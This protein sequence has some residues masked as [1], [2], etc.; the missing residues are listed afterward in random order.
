MNR[1][2]AILLILSSLIFSRCAPLETIATHD[3]SSGYYRLDVKDANPS[4]V[5]IDLN[6][7]SLTLFSMKDGDK[8]NPDPGS[9]KHF[10][11]SEL[12]PENL[13][14]SARF[15][16]N[17]VDA[18]LATIITKYRP[19][20]DGVP[21][22]MNS[23]LNAALYVGARKDFFSI[24]QHKQVFRSTSF[25]RQTGFDAGLFAGFG[26]SFISPTV[27]A[28]RTDREYDGIIF[29]KGAAVFFTYDHISLGLACGFDN[30]FG[31]DSGIWIYNNKP[32]I[33]LSLG[34]ANF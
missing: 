13:L 1:I 4:K 25:V 10:N 20:L 22:Q 23:N 12:S 32:W 21:P 2:Q 29:Q 26:M 5:Y 16:R 15:V 27:T 17:S 19:A 14:Y 11:I 30:L 34:I 6:N 31:P 24:R 33:G 18:D 3:F 28:G 7:D 9:A 8:V